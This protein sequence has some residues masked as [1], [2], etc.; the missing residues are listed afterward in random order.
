M[1]AT[2]FAVL[3]LFSTSVAADNPNLENK[4][5][6]EFSGNA[7]STGQLVLALAPKGQPAVEVTVPIPEKTSENG[8]AAAVVKELRL[9]LGEV[10]RVER[11]D[12]EDVLIKRRRGGPT[13]SVVL[14]ENT[15]QGVRVNFQQE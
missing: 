9:R 5:R 7:E 8:V 12:G 15:V 6:L 4:W 10:Y 2:F 1:R 13:F 3:L 14:V 11:D